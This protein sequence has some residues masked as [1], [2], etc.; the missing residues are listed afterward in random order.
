MPKF[1]AMEEM[2]FLLSTNNTRIDLFYIIDCLTEENQRISNIIDNIDPQ[3]IDKINLIHKA[4]TYILD[5]S[6]DLS[7]KIDE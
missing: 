2:D 7:A 1:T 3:D 4:L 6:T 5:L